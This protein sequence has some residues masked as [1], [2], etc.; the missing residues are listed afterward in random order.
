MNSGSSRFSVR[1]TSERRE[2]ASPDHRV[3]VGKR[4]RIVPAHC[5]AAVNPLDTLWIVEGDRV[6]V[7]W[8]VAARG[9]GR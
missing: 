5:C 3:R 1:G 4:L 2:T 9:T 7:G 8:A 6:L